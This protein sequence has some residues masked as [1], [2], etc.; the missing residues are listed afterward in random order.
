MSLTE[1]LEQSIDITASL[2]VVDRCITDRDLMHRWLNPLLRC[3]P[4][5]DWNTNVGSRS[6]FIVQIPLI[7]P[8]LNNVVVERSPGLVVWEFQGFF[9]GRD[10]WECQTTH[11]GIH[12]INRFEFIIPNPIVRWGFNTFAFTLTQKD[13]QAQLHRLKRLAEAIESK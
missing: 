11:Q 2:S 4:V 10:R 7:A 12:L 6:R 5:G 9:Q 1:V 13:M 3:Q 8:T